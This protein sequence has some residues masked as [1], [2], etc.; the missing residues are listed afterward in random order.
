MYNT[1]PDHV[2]TRRRRLIVSQ[3]GPSHVSTAPVVPRVF[4]SS[5]GSQGSMLSTVIPTIATVSN[6]VKPAQK[7]DPHTSYQHAT[8][9]LVRP[10]APLVRLLARPRVY[11]LFLNSAKVCCLHGK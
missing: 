3:P 8:R 11:T 7:R 2:T 9:P 5:H 1:Y 4:R 10:I 6:G